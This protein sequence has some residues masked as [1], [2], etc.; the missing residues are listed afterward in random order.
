MT[1]SQNGHKP[2]PNSNQNNVL[3]YG[4]QPVT[5]HSDWCDETEE[6]LDASPSPWTSR[7]LWL[8]I[9]FFAVALPWS[10]F[11]KVEETGTAK[12]QLEPN[13]GT[14]KVE[15]PLSGRFAGVEVKQVPV[16]VGDEVNKGDILVKLDREKLQL[17]LQQQKAQLNSLQERLSRVKRV[18]KQLQAS[19]N[20]QELQKQSQIAEQ[21]AKLIQIQNRIE[22]RQNLLPIE[23][24]RLTKAKKNLQRYRQLYE[25][26]AV[27]KRELE[28]KEAVYEQR[29][30]QLQQLRADVEQSQLKLKQQRSSFKRIK[31]TGQ[32]A[33]IDTK[34][35]LEDT[36][37]Q[38]ANLEG[39]IAQKQGQIKSLQDQLQ[40]RTIRSPHDG[41]IFKM[42]VSKPNEVLQAGQ[43]V[44]KIAPQDDSLVLRANLPARETGSL[45]KGMD[46]RIK[47]DAYPYQD[48]GVMKGTLQKIAPTSQQQKTP[49]GRVS[50][51]DVEI[52]LAQKCIQ[53]KHGC[54]E[55]KP[56]DTAKAEVVVRKKRVID[57]VIE[58][59][60]KLQSGGIQL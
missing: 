12:G 38:I 16:S 44:A 32:E 10:Y 30:K 39:Q 51:F 6:F 49:K 43:V 45:E 8:L 17:Q 25:E 33:V 36:K 57:Y 40:R 41:T 7:L 23:K 28:K 13:S 4:T 56:G 14:T 9:I 29:K 11:S 26:G 24:S 21:E 31:G 15:A 46:V 60:K 19:L 27:T 54:I 5:T 20:T 22:N 1:D 59:F 2:I 48:Y 52:E 3:D 42:P 50:T 37:S 58:P 53:T 18:Y 34:R 55:L 35:Q 47:F